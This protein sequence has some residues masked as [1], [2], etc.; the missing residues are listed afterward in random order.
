MSFS[1]HLDD[2]V[3][4]IG[5]SNRELAQASGLSPAAISRYRSG[6]RVP[7]ADSAQAMALENGLRALAQARGVAAEELDR[8]F[9]TLGSL[10]RISASESTGAKLDALLSAAGISQGR[11]ARTMNYDPSY[12][13]RICSGER[14]PGDFGAFARGVA[15]LV[16]STCAPG[17]SREG[18]LKLCGG[19]S[20]DENLVAA[21]VSWL[22]SP[23]SARTAAIESFAR[24]LDEF[25]LGSYLAAVD[26]A[27][28]NAQ[29]QNANG[30]TSPDVPAA[31]GDTS[32]PEI[33]LGIERLC[34]GELDFLKLASAEPAGTSV[35]FYS[36]SPM[37]DM[38]A[39]EGFPA[40][41]MMGLATLL[42]TGHHI[43]SIHNVD[44]HLPEMLLG[45]E[46]WIPCYMT[47]LVKS[48]YLPSK[49]DPSFWHHIRSAETVTLD[50]EGIEGHHDRMRYVLSCDPQEVAWRRERALQLLDRARVLAETYTHATAQ[51]FSAFMDVEAR[52]GG[53]HG[54]YLASPPLYTMSEDLLERCLANSGLDES[55]LDRARETRLV[56][57]RRVEEILSRGTCDVEI[58][59]LPRDSFDAA[60]ARLALGEAFCGRD[61]CYTQELYEEHVALTNRFAS[62]HSSWDLTWGDDRG[63]RNIQIQWKAGAWATAAKTTSPAIIFMFEHPKIVQA[64]EEMH[65]PIVDRV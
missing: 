23:A 5:C 31:P 9:V 55:E 26:F 36:D 11:L 22:C 56:Q 15:Q 49:R 16:D 44:R 1:Q 42:K 60:P 10:T 41:W 39:V 2:L 28:H 51:R 19:T 8:A 13:S 29:G 40:R 53:R 12:I 38:A 14:L 24:K 7:R 43:E 58:A 30:Q 18:I 27:A 3:A 46:A 4:K 65:M 48:Y 57:M 20:G 37:E 32:N 61:V 17:A 34:Q 62:E 59:L 6:S 50:G 47:G 45:L 64:I 52:S 35:V 25:D 63:L 54:A 33:Y 21:V